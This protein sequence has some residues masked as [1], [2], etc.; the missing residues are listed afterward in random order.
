MFSILFYL[1]PIFHSLPHFFR[2]HINVVLITFDL[3]VSGLHSG[4][5][6]MRGFNHRLVESAFC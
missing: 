1:Y 3:S 5:V 4:V 6:C 2:N